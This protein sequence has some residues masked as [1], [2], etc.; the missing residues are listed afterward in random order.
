[1]RNEFFRLYP[2]DTHSAKKET[3]PRGVNDAVNRSL[4]NS[5]HVG[6]D[7]AQTVLWMT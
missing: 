7:L 2:A 6:T 4:M 5:I 3:F 1:M